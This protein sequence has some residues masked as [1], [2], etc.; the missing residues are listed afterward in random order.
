MT[1]ILLLDKQ[2]QACKPPLLLT[3]VGENIVI[4][5]DWIIHELIFHE[6]M[7]H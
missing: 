3:I 4:H 5:R 2:R 6:L 1:Q 7:I